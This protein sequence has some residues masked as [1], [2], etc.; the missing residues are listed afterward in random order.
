MRIVF[1]IAVIVLV[2]PA[3]A[4]AQEGL[5]LEW[6]GRPVDTSW[7]A[8][9][10]IWHEFHPNYC[11]D[12]VQTGH[13]DD[14]SDG[15]IDVCEHIVFEEGRAHIEWVGPTFKLVRIGDPRI[16]K[17]IEPIAANGGDGRDEWFHEV[18]PNFCAEVHTPDV[19]EYVCQEI[20]ID[21]PPEDEGWWHVLEI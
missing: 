2:L 20:Y 1:A 21:F 14:N 9:G 7:P 4:P 6:M 3:T 11:F 13:E 12:R 10:S 17:F 5:A 19:I 15:M 18:Y 16:E 8:D